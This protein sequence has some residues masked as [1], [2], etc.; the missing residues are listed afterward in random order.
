VFNG[1]H[2][3]CTRRAI[4]R[5]EREGLTYEAGRSD[6]LLLA[7]YGLLRQTRRRHRLPPQPLG[8]FRN[9]AACFGSGLL[10][11]LASKDGLPV[12]GILT[13]SFKNT[14]VYKYGGSDARFHPLGGMPFLFWH[15]IQGAKARGAEEL[16]LGRSA[17]DQPGLI[18]FKRH[19]GAEEST[20]T[21]YT[22]PE[23]AGHL[24]QESPAA[25]AALRFIAQLPDAAFDLT[26][27]LLYKY[28]G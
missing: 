25:R 22:W 14:V 27:R 2:H 5:A 6:R 18:A 26:G 3:S 12:A 17:L 10:I 28:L 21:Y 1:F 23:R 8:W 11:H 20:L 24:A 16:D 9:L 19:L 4:R 13:L 7:F 15:A